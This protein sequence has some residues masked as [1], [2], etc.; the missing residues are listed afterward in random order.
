MQ[1]LWKIVWWLIRKLNIE[2]AHDPAIQILG[3]YLKELKAGTQTDT[4]TSMCIAAFFTIVKRQK[5]PK[6]SLTYK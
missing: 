2:L 4:C 6:C 3:I 1:F 5:Q